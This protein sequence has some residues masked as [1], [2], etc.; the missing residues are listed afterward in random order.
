MGGSSKRGSMSE[1]KPGLHEL[2]SG[3]L[4][5]PG[6][7]LWLVLTVGFALGYGS[8]D[9]M[10]GRGAQNNLSSQQEVDDLHIGRGNGRHE[11]QA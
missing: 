5:R 8:K 4:V 7:G 1:R 3:M 10:K 9:G 2:S 6:F 11:R